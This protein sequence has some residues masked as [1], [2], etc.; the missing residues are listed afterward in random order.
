MSNQSPQ[1]DSWYLTLIRYA[2]T[3]GGLATG[4]SIAQKIT[5]QL[6]LQIVIALITGLAAWFISFIDK[7]RQKIEESLVDQ[8][9]TWLPTALR[10]IFAGYRKRYLY[11][12]AQAHKFVELYGLAQRPRSGRQLRPI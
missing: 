11:G 6:G 8:T 1:R 3:L 5:P 12:I 7:V 9:A 10:N 4:Y 2:L